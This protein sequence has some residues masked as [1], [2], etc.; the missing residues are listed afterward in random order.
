MTAIDAGT[1]VT[2][3]GTCQSG[4]FKWI[5]VESTVPEEFLKVNLGSV[6]K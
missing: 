5:V 6:N 4:K 3:E 1:R 2:F